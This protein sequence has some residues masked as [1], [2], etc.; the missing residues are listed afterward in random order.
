MTPTDAGRATGPRTDRCGAP[1]AYRRLQA[2]RSDALVDHEAHRA[3][4]GR[5]VA[6]RVRRGV[7]GLDAVLAGLARLEGPA[8]G[9]VRGADTGPGGL[10]DR[11][12]EPD[13]EL[14]RAALERRLAGG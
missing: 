6:G 5:R 7:A 14:H 8:V 3:G 9:A 10:H 4:G 2:G 13:R 11:T 1:L 12:V